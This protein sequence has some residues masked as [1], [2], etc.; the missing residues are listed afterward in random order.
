MGPVSFLCIIFYL[1]FSL[2]CCPIYIIY[3]IFYFYISSPLLYYYGCFDLRIKFLI[4]FWSNSCASSDL[5]IELMWLSGP[6]IESRIVGWGSLLSQ[7]VRLMRPDKAATCHVALVLINSC[8]EELWELV[9]ESTEF[10]F[11]TIYIQIVQIGKILYD[12]TKTFC[13][14][15][16][17]FNRGLILKVYRLLEFALYHL[18]Q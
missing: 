14:S 2:T 4:S 9:R 5:S 11:I 6:S 16:M 13:F 18:G 8:S 15:S 17:T 10:D 7:Y 3:T 12:Q 1:V